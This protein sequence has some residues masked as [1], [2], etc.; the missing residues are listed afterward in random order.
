MQ[1]KHKTQIPLNPLNFSPIGIDCRNAK[2]NLGR[3]YNMSSSNKVMTNPFNEKL[4]EIIL[5]WG[6]KD[7]KNYE[8]IL[9][10][11]TKEKS[12]QKDPKWEF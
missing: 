1:Q 12:N 8:N 11:S 10:N 2:K 6:S 9:N 3:Q 4:E 7:C 5:Y